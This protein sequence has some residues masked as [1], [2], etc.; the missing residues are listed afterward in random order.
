MPY[1]EMGGVENSLT[2][3]LRLKNGTAGSPQKIYE[4]TSSA[5]IL[6]TEQRPAG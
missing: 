5:D 2:Q 4:G 1:Q 3:S 6:L